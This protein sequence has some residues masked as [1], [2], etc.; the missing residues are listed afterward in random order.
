ML[1][2]LQESVG[3]GD[4][5]AEGAEIFF[6]EP[7]LRAGKNTGNLLTSTEDLSIAQ[8]IFRFGDSRY[9]QFAS[10]QLPHVICVAFRS[11]QLVVAAA[12][13][14]EKIF[15]KL[16]NIGRTDKIIEPKFTDAPAQVNPEV[17]VIEHAKLLVR[18]RQQIIAEIVKGRRVDVFTTQQ[19]TDA[20]T[21]FC[22]GIFRVG[23]G[24]NFLWARVAALNQPRN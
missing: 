3:A 6:Q 20:I 15:Q 22:R 4:H 12:E 18:P 10:L 17:G 23:E 21:H 5:V 2:A 14:L 7:A 19:S 24:E 16:A 11:D 13:K 8:L 1:V 9:G